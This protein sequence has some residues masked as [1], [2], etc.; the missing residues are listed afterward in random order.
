MLFFSTATKNIF[1]PGPG[2]RAK[3]FD[4]WPLLFLL[5]SL[6]STFS[7]LYTD[8]PTRLVNL[9]WNWF[10]VQHCYSGVRDP[11]PGH[12]AFVLGHCVRAVLVEKWLSFII[13][14][15]PLSLS[16]L[17]LPKRR[18]IPHLRIFLLISLVRWEWWRNALWGAFRRITPTLTPS[19]TAQLLSRNL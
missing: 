11:G 1:M 4:G 14:S 17:L 13:S 3:I 2:P 6:Q 19:P 5:I 16:F 10:L 18:H 8:Y 12:S 15:M 9:P 7:L